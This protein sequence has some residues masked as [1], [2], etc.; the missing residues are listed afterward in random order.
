ML[1]ELN[2]WFLGHQGSNYAVCTTALSARTDL[3][4]GGRRLQHTGVSPEV[5]HPPSLTLQSTDTGV[6]H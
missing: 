5:T 1:R 3:G 2:S 4:A 6:G